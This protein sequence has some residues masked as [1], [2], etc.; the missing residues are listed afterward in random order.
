MQAIRAA[1]AAWRSGPDVKGP[2]P[3]G[4]VRDTIEVLL[5]TSMRPGEALALRPSDI[6]DGRR[7]MVAHVRGTVIY[8]Q[9]RGTFRQDHPKTD[10]SVRQVPVP[11]FAAQVLR[12]RIAP[13]GP[14]QRDR[15]IFANRSGGRS[16]S[17][18]SGVRSGSSLSLPGLRTPVLRRGGTDAPVR[19]CW[20]VGSA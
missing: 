6:A 9:G 12:R 20:P 11:E 14:E 10:A 15:T 4:Q 19:R 2:K 8:G 1:A 5:G 17:T 3:D 16:A 18:M 13:L 7:G